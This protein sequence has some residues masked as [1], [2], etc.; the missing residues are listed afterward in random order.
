MVTGSV[1]APDGLAAIHPA[2]IA[3]LAEEGGLG[4]TGGNRIDPDPPW[5]KLER[6]GDIGAGLFAI[7]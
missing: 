2:D 6:P 7:P 5:C 4:R 3:H 1:F